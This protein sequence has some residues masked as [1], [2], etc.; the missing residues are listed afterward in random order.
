MGA[1]MARD[2]L[3]DDAIIAQIKSVMDRMSVMSPQDRISFL[4]SVQRILGGSLHP[5]DQESAH[6]RPD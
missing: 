4:D 6:V 5:L 2:C 3:G 1:R